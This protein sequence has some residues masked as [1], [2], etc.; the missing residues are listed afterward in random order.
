ML[1]LMPRLAVVLFLL[2]STGLAS[3]CCPRRC[4]PRTNTVRVTQR[5]SVREAVPESV[6]PLEEV[7]PPA[8]E[9]LESIVVYLSAEGPFVVRWQGTE[10]AKGNMATPEEA[11]SGVSQLEEV[12]AEI[13]ARPGMREPTGESRLKLIV[14]GTGTTRWRY[15]QWIMQACAAT[16]VR[17][18]KMQFRTKKPAE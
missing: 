5:P 4:C 2:L 7:A 15:V 11:E 1:R 8:D 3:C 16:N 6:T 17:I 10:I 12:L 13:T 9:E 18:Y 14:E